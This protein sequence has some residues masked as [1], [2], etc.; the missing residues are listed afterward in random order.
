VS[1]SRLYDIA[2]ELHQG[3]MAELASSG[4][5]AP[6]VHGVYHGDIAFDS[7]CDGMLWVRWTSVYLTSSFPIEVQAFAPCHSQALVADYEVGLLR[8]VPRVQTAGRNVIL[9]TPDELAASALELASDAQAVL[10]GVCGTATGWGR[11]K[12]YVMG[13]SLPVNTEGG[14]GG[15]VVPVTVEL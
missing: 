1:A 13:R 9:P 11:E 4:L 7:C 10:R 12:R 14:C 6:L 8:C 5:V 3:V 2:E 15:S